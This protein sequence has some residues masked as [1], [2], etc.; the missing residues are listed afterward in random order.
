M[1]PLVNKTIKIKVEVG[2][3]PQSVVLDDLADVITHA[4]SSSSLPTLNEIRTM[5]KGKTDL[6]DGKCCGSAVKQSN[7]RH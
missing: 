1:V 4:P 6:R 3:F 7:S 2:L 5:K